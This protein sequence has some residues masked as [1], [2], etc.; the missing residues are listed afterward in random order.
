MKVSKSQQ[1]YMETKLAH[2]E[3]DRSHPVTADDLQRILKD[4]ESREEELRANALQE[5]CPCRV[6]WESFELFRKPALRLRKDPSPVV[7]KLAHHI[8]E[9]AKEVAAL[10][11]QRERELEREDSVTDRGKDK[12]RRRRE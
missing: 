4:L 9:D 2:V 8:E 5:V 6:S 3:H 10:E 12:S 1:E 7:R 11:A